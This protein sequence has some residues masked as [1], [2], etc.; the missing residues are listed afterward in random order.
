M[1][2]LMQNDYLTA[3]RMPKSLLT[4]GISIFLISA[5]SVQADNLADILALDADLDFGEYLA[6]ECSACHN[7]N[8]NTAALS[9]VPNIH[10][11]DEQSLVENLLAYRTGERENSTMRGVAGGLSN[12]E[13][14]ALAAYLAS[15]E[16]VSSGGAETCG[17]A[18]DRDANKD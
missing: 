13:I 7:P 9:A 15:L 17:D 16:T 3:S 8:S 4:L 12:D 14:A 18:C 2:L 10:G 6:G 11:A 1:S 5:S